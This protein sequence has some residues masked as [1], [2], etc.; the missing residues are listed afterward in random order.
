MENQIPEETKH[1]RF[2]RVVEAVNESVIRNNKRYE[3]RVVEVL[4]EGP[5]KH[6][7]GK[8][9]GRTREGRLVNFVGSEDTIGKL[10]NVK[11]NRA[12][13]FS[14]LGEVVG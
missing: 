5:S 12:Q 13:P 1:E 10:V 3:G 14:L 6:D 7:A 11:I 4:V 8:L 2:N 9:M